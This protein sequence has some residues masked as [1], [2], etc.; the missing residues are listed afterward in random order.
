GRPLI[1]IAGEL[2]HIEAFRLD[3]I[4][5][6]SSPLRELDDLSAAMIQM[7]HGLTSFQ[8]YLP[9]EL[10][11]TLV[12]RGIEAKPGGEQ[13]T[14]S[15]LFADLAGFTSLSERLGLGIVPI[16]TD[17]LSSTSRAII[18]EGG[19]IDKF[20]GDAVMAFWGAPLPNAQHAAAACR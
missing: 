11:R 5:R 1:R 9:T 7:A 6:I 19:T 15:V 3:R 4:R 16:L 13:Q 18:A 8:K 10:V 2:H 14:L 12:S 20:I 17:Y